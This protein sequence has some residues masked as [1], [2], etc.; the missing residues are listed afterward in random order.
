MQQA[1]V[2]YESWFGSSR[3]VAERIGEGLRGA[4]VDA[5][6]VRLDRADLD[7]LDTADL[8]V[9]GGPTHAHSI[10]NEATRREA[11]HWAEDPAKK[12]TL[13]VDPAMSGLREWL[14]GVEP[15][16]QRFAAF[17]TRA[18][19]A[20]LLSGSASHVIR[21]R[22]RKKG[23][24]EF[25]PDESFIVPV[26][27]TITEGELSR[28]EMWGRQLGGALSAATAGDVQRV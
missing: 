4:G 13:E 17:S 11:R 22:L 15:G 21:R 7:T 8:V 18:D 2:L 19:I 6:V 3:R 23:W 20:E 28:A 12:L 14:D 27:G 9:V 25:A 1:A 24:G 10:S 26:S 16:D 5:N